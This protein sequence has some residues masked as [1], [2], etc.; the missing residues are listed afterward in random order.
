MSVGPA[1]VARAK[2]L[3]FSG[4][5]VLTTVN[6]TPFLSCGIGMVV[7]QW[8]Y[9]LYKEYRPNQND[10]WHSNLIGISHFLECLDTTMNACIMRNRTALTLVNAFRGAASELSARAIKRGSPQLIAGFWLQNLDYL[11]T[12]RNC[13]YV[14]ISILGQQYLNTICGSDGHIYSI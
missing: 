10:S 7:N 11:R 13:L 3:A 8:Y 6:A 9:A 2:S 4:R 14:S 12:G 5:Y 1:N